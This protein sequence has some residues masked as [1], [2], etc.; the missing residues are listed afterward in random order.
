MGHQNLPLPKRYEDS[1]RLRWRSSD[2]GHGHLRV[3]APWHRMVL[4]VKAQALRLRA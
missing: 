3:L 4:E 1:K 2:S